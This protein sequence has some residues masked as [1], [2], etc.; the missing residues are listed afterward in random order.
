MRSRKVLVNTIANVFNILAIL[1]STLIVPRLIINTFG[2]DYNGLVSSISQFIG[3]SMLLR[4]GI[5]PVTR[6]ALYKPLAQ[7]DIKT[8]SE[9]VL[10]T[11]KFMRK[12][13]YV[14]SVLLLLMAC[15]YPFFVIDDF[16]WLFSFSLVLII[17][18][19]EAVRFFV[20]ITYQTLI[21]AD[22]KQYLISGINIVTTIL[23]II[24]SVLTISIGVD[25]RIVM[26]ITAA[27][28]SINPIFI[29]IYSK[30]YYRFIENVEPD[31]TA[32]RQR[33]HAFAISLTQFVNNN[34]DIIIITIFLDVYEVSVYSVYYLAILG[35]QQIFITVTKGI[36]NFFGDMIAR[37]EN[38]L[39]YKNLRIYELVTFVF[40]T[41]V[42]SVAIIQLT[43]FVSVYTAGV[44]DIY[45][46]RPVFGIMACS[47]AFFHCV[48]T[49]YQSIVEA[50]GHF[51]QTRN[52]AI[53]EVAM[54][55]ALSLV[56]V[57]V[58]GITGAVIGM[59][60]S[61]I[62]RTFQYSYY[63][64][65]KIVQK[66]FIL[67][68]KRLLLSL[69]AICIVLSISA[70]LD[71]DTPSNYTQWITNSCV[72]SGIVLPIILAVNLIFYRDEM[73]MFYKKVKS[74]LKKKRKGTLA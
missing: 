49:P 1:I 56:L 74:G 68:V 45:Y 13:A 69:S 18:I 12:I 8:V 64:Y 37:G 72:Y 6:A 44:T 19:R 42:F 67:F 71:M 59:L 53:V 33:W 38:E 58:V 27:L 43:P 41:F 31:Y 47:A 52:G 28:S 51:K 10:A 14:F 20:G 24:A 9:I 54:H 16:V 17:G 63:L 25:L 39:M 21:E 36:G 46:Y 61:G 40:T 29:C 50:A 48:R 7:K 32:I 35:I 62:F 73:H 70:F 66:R 4:M 57:Q 2:S 60:A 15:L 65:K 55:I 22:Q 3:W 23:I 34:M 11:K 26:L 5:L 30:Q